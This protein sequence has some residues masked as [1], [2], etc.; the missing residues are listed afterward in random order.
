LLAAV[1]A[2]DPD[3]PVE[4]AVFVGVA[5]GYALLGGIGT[6][7]AIGDV[8]ILSLPGIVVALSVPI[9]TIA[10]IVRD[11]A[12]DGQGGL[13]AFVIAV[14]SLVGLGAGLGVVEWRG[15][16]PLHRRGRS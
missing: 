6:A 9:T 3:L 5:Y 1:V 13:A 10:V 2:F 12:P 16:E 8:R 11:P 14:V 15:K 4:P 7:A